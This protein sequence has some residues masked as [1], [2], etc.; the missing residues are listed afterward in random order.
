MYPERTS[1]Q[2]QTA[3]QRIWGTFRP[4]QHPDAASATP[5]GYKESLKCT[6]DAV[7]RRRRNQQ[8]EEQ[9]KPSSPPTT[10]AKSCVPVGK[11]GGNNTIESTTKSS[12]WK[13]MLL[14]LCSSKHNEPKPNQY[15][16]QKKM[17]TFTWGPRAAPLVRRTS[18]PTV[19]ATSSRV[20]Q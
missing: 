6:F 12:S 3:R 9:E 2:I 5:C 17:Q 14:I 18:G 7:K 20:V 10:K 16:Y 1:R 19:H 4:R 11:R 13:L 8:Q 15:Q